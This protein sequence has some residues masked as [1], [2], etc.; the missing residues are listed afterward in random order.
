MGRGLGRGLYP[1]PENL[2]IFELKMVRYGAFWVL[3]L[4]ERSE[5][6]VG[7]GGECGDDV[8]LSRHYTSMPETQEM[9]GRADCQ[10]VVERDCSSPCPCPSIAYL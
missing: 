2:L 8:L 9:G 6:V 5:G 1:F 3:F 10:S 7:E 4:G